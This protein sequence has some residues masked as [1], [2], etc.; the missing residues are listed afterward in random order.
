MNLLSNKTIVVTGASKGIGLEMVRLFVNEGANVIA[1]SRS[2]CSIDSKFVTNVKLDVS[3]YYEC[4]EKLKDIISKFDKIDGLV[5]NAGVTKDCMTYKMDEDSFDY[6][7]QTNLKGV[8][9]VVRI[10]GPFME[11]QG[12][13]SIVNISSIVGEYGNIGQCNYAASKAGIIGMSK[14]WAKEFS[15]KG[16]QI[17]VN[18]ICPGY[19]LTDMLKT[20][21][22][23]LL[24]KFKNMTMLKR[25]GNPIEIANSAMFLLS[26]LASYI[27]GVVLDV[28]GGMRL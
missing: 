14:S 15:R 8:F 10:I 28:N 6:V 2:G 4:D 12:F 1:C 17:R 20:V 23:D 18:V 24:D 27:T 3:N 19:I 7:M 11:K 9:N 21:P 26:D 5:C 22:T 16:N 25:L 13:G